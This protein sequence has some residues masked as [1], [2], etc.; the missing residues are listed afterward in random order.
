MFVSKTKRNERKFVHRSCKVGGLLTFA[1][2]YRTD[3]TRRSQ[4]QT[5][6]TRRVT[7]GQRISIF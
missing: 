4:S 2:G 5:T 7:F 3:K 6:K 1:F